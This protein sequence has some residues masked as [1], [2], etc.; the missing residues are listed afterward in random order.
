MID[1][2]DDDGIAILRIV[3]GPVN[4]LDAEL[5]AALA[6]ALD[7]VEGSGA[8]AAILTGSG[9]A[10]SAGADLIRLLDEGRDYVEAARPHADRAFE[11]MFTIPIPV[12]A[13][14]NGHAIAGGCVIALA[15][16]H[17][18]TVTGDHRMGLAELKVGVPFPMWALEAVRFALSPP[19]LQR[20]IYSGGLLAPSDALAAGLVDEIVPPDQLM[21]RALEKAR[22]LAAIPA[23]TF[24]L[25]KRTLRE[26]FA[27][28]ARDAKAIDDEGAAVWGSTEARESVRR[29]IERTI[30]RPE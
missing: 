2:T 1:T 4:A 9:A 3:H 10:F 16:D 20:L 26:P 11:R 8:R 27:V 23:A 7:D 24:A 30:G 21:E 6:D 19:H 13:A 14:I 28:R 29:F 25:T 12:V 18:I 17:R 15:C 5:L 22:R